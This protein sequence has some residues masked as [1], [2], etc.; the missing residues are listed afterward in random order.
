MDETQYHELFLFAAKAGSLEGYL[1]QRQAV[2]PLTDWVDNITR[3][4][5]ELS[6]VVRKDIAPATAV[7]LKRA[8]EYGDKLLESGLKEKLQQLLTLAGKAD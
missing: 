2:E 1:F 3:M 7:V 5:D 4:Y 6:P 8:L